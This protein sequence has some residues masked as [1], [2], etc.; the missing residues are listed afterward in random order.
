MTDSVRHLGDAA[1]EDAPTLAGHLRL[2]LLDDDGAGCTAYFPADQVAG[3]LEA[4]DREELGGRT[5]R[6]LG[7]T[8]KG[9]ARLRERAFRLARERRDLEAGMLALW[10]AMSGPAG[11]EVR[12]QVSAVLAR[13]GKAT[14]TMQRD[15][16]TR[17]VAT[18]VSEDFAPVPVPGLARLG[19]RLPRDTVVAVG[20]TDDAPPAH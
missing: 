5:L 9:W 19:G 2:T 13:A 4:M 15:R 18:I 10:A 1:P 3:L 11:P 7:G 20:G 8:A 17:A 6:E 14:V 16:G 12:R